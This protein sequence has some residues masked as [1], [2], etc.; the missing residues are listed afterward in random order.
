IEDSKPKMSEKEKREM[1]D[2]ILK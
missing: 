1:I 2:K